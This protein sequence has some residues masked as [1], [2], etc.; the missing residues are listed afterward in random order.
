MKIFG[1]IKVPCEHI[2]ND[3]MTQGWFMECVANEIT[4]EMLN[5]N[6][7][8]FTE[9]YDHGYYIMDGEVDCESTR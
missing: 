4:K 5:K 2:A 6:L 8:S 1:E 9:R 7:I 3:R